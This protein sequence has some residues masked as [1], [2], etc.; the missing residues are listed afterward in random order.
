M[1]CFPTV[2]IEKGKTKNNE[3]KHLAIT[4]HTVRFHTLNY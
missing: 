4:T 3:R 1:K 2:L